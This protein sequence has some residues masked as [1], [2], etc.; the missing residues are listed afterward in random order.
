MSGLQRPFDAE[1]P[2]EQCHLVLALPEAASTHGC[3]A[4]PPRFIKSRWGD[5]PVNGHWVTQI[6]MESASGF[7]LHPYLLFLLVILFNSPIS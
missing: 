3:T 4:G 2:A 1:Y 7:F 5:C 6:C